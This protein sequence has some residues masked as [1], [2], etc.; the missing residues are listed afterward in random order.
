[1][2]NNQLNIF[3]YSKIIIY[4]AFMAAS[5]SKNQLN[6]ARKKFY[7]RFYVTKENLSFIDKLINKIL[8]YLYL[9]KYTLINI[10]RKIYRL[11]DAFLNRKVSQK[12]ISFSISLNENSVLKISNDLKNKNF[13]FIENFLSEESYKYLINNW[14]N[15]N[16]FNHNKQ[17]IKHYN[18]KVE[19]PIKNSF[20]KFGESNEI[21]NFCLFLLSREFKKFYDILL[22]F[23]KK[24]Y[25]VCAISSSMAPRESYLIPHVDGVIK[26]SETQQHYNFIYFL[27]GYDQNP[28]L[29]GGTGF[30]KDNEFEYPIF[31]PRT[32]KNSLVI[33]N[34]SESFYH[35][36]RTIECPKDIYRKTINFQ[37]KPVSA[38]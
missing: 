24:N 8:I 30:Y 22:S 1:L 15:I 17:I 6:F 38:K 11:M 34:Q 27:D 13:T 5:F 25:E 32:I 31:I 16:Y 7:G 35:G 4:L 23:E 9:I 12:T 28:I 29:G 33:Y 20:F 18:A 21:K 2:E 36:F 10:K 19:W 37:I 14:P 26:N 3:K